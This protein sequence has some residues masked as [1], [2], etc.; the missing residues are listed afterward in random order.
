M[1]VDSKWLCG[2][3]FEVQSGGARLL[4]LH[5][6]ALW[7]RVPGAEYVWARPVSSLYDSVM[8]HGPWLCMHAYF[9]PCAGG[10]AESITSLLKAA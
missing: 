6:A 10:G 2:Q 3:Q 5:N 4:D 9:D 1:G 8:W 7:F